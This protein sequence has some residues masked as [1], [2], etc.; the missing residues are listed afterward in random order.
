MA[1]ST[2]KARD[3]DTA[4][5]SGRYTI[6][7]ALV[8]AAGGLMFGYDIGVIADVLTDVGQQFDL[9]DFGKGWVASI[10]LIGSLIGALCAGRL[11]DRY[12]RR[13]TNFV[14]GIL[15]MVGSVGCA[16]LDNLALFFVARFLMGLG[17]GFA[18]VAGPLYIAE[19]SAPWNR[20]AMVSLYQLAITIGIFLAFIAGMFLE[21]L[22]Y[23]RI[24][25]ALG[26]LTGLGLAV[27][28]IVMPPS[29]RWLAGR[30]RG[31]EAKRVLA[32]TLG[33]EEAAA[34]EYKAISERLAEEHGMTLL[35]ALRSGPVVYR[36][37]I[38]AVGLALLQQLSG[39]NALM[40]YAPE[41]FQEVGLGSTS[42][43]FAA[44]TGLGFINVAA[45]FIAIWLVDRVGRKPILV[46]GAG[47]MCVAELLL[48]GAA[49]FAVP[50]GAPSAPIPVPAAVGHAH[51]AASSATA[52]YIIDRS[53]GTAAKPAAESTAKPAAD[54]TAEPTTS[55]SLM[56]LVAVIMTVLAVIA[57]AF[58]LGPIVWLIIS[59]IFPA[60]VRSPCVGLATA[61]NWLGNWLIAMMSLWMIHNLGVSTLFW[62]FA[63]FNLFTVFFVCF[64]M[65]ET[66]GVELEQI[67]KFFQSPSQKATAK[68]KGTR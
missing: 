60:G 1:R 7:V 17:V 64:R 45:T 63:G 51:A 43:K 24:D 31:A 14:G 30:G 49:L 32:R 66:K 50:G 13:W 39:M 8:A 67:E 28:M 38:L 4:A 42:S 2:N 46:V 55:L 12:G 19:V 34:E 29:P 23:W 26:A 5:A 57:F 6:A 27:G 61:A 11:A 44:T 59:E 10:V 56:G 58:S 16:L 41:I 15:F 36:A 33:S 47:M 53:E 65:P 25:F 68:P 37:L 52:R 21:P 3:R 9:G 48:G 40:Y 35:K 62:I 20:G 54:A 22:G 18:S